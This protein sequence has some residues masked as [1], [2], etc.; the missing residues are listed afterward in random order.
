MKNLITKNKININININKMNIYYN[1]KQMFYSI[2]NN[3]K[4]Q[5]YNIFCKT[6]F[7]NKT[8]IYPDGLNEVLPNSISFSDNSFSFSKE[9]SYIILSQFRNNIYS[10]SLISIPKSLRL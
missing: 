9:F 4:F 1:V 5:F 10:P 7:S 3:C 2:I 6:G 8:V